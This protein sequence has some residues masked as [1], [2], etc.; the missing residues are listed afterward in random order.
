MLAVVRRPRTKKPI[1]EIKGEI[2][3]DVLV[4]LKK[5]YTVDI[6][7]DEA[8]VDITETDWHKEMKAR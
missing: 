8:Y 7:N 5:K 3:D 6:D 4:F 1:F 2:P